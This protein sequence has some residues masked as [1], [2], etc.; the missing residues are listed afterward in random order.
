MAVGPNDEAGMDGGAVGADLAASS[1]GFL[2]WMGRVLIEL[3]DL[4]S[5]DYGLP[6]EA[7]SEGGGAIEE[8]LMKDGA[9]HAAARVVGE[10]CL[11]GDGTAGGFGG[12]EANAVED[13]ALDGG[14]VDAEAQEGVDGT[15]QQALAAGFVDGRRHAIG[16]EDAEAVLGCGDGAGPTRGTASGDKDIRIG[17]HAA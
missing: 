16:Y 10:I 12:K 14:D 15:R 1:G 17:F 9:A 3:R 5:E 7:D 11:R 4:H 6:T 2:P 13:G 8:E